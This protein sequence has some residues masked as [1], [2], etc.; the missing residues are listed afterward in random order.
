MRSR[1][2]LLADNVDLVLEEVAQRAADRIEALLA[3]AALYR[4]I[5][6]EVSELDVGVQRTRRFAPA[7]GDVNAKLRGEHVPDDQGLTVETIRRERAELVLPEPHQPARPYF[8]RDETKRCD[9]VA[10]HTAIGQSRAGVILGVD[11]PEL[12]EPLEQ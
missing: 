12:P 4:A 11:E 7:F 8:Q 9:G 3:V 10:L 1:I 2:V 6:D 5:V